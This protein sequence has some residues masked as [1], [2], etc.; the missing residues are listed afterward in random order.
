MQRRFRQVDVFTAVPYLGNPVAVILD[1]DGLTTERMQ[2]IARWTNL[3][4]T[5]FVCSPTDPSADY[6][7]RI[8]CPTNEMRFAG[9]PTI[10]SAHALLS[11]GFIPKQAGT[12]V[13]QCGVGLVHLQTD[14]DG[15]A[16]ALPPALMTP[17]DAATH[18][19]VEEAIGARLLEAPVIVDIGVEWLTGQVASGEALRALK[20]S[21]DGMAAIARRVGAN[22]NMFGLDGDTVEVRSFAPNE[23]TPE[24]PVCGSGNGAVAYY[25]RERRGTVDYH[26]RQGRCVGR[27]GHIR[28]SHDKDTIWLGGQAVNCIEGMIQA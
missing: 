6:L 22:V 19:E 9:H 18:R 15:I 2:T 24:D 7:L 3:S 10:G 16:I 28:V 5:T 14:D 11:S 4:E 20:P 25:L 8:F 21:M 12:L 13:Q 1:G 17:V 26:A 23:S 27:D